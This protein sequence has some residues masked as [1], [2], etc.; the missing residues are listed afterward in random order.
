M[1][2]SGKPKL[3]F[4]HNILQEVILRGIYFHLNTSINNSDREV[5]KR[6]TKF[7]GFG[8][9]FSQTLTSEN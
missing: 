5:F 8:F 4:D 6:V 2:S 7:K 9:L 3:Y 1:A